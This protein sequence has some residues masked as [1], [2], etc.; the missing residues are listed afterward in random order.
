MRRREA[1]YGYLF[2][3]IWIIGY[4]IFSLYPVIFSLVLSFQEAHFEVGGYKGTFVGIDNYVSI[5][6][7][8]NV[9]PLLINYLGQII[10]SVPLIIVFA[11]IISLLINQPIR[12]KGIWRTIFFLPVVISTGPV[13]RTLINQEATSLP[14]I[15]N[16]P[17][18]EFIITNLGSNLATPI[19]TVLESLL[20]IL[21]YA[22]IPILIFLSALQRNER[23]IYEAAA[24]DGASPW[25]IFWKITLPT[26]MP[27]VTVNIVYVVVNL[28][29]TGDIAGVLSEAAIQS[30]GD[31]TNIRYYGYGYSSAITWIYFIM[32][33]SII[34]IFVGIVSFRGR[35]EARNERKYKKQYKRKIAQLKKQA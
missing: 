29:I 28:S 32:M 21:W 11:L 31:P 6:K 23:A 8:Q 2:I 18:I 27:F 26:I 35:R 5:F 10:I 33:V 9:L 20:L 22:G 34:G 15:T 16:N 25:D 30:S 19:T 4:L 3:S 1:L 7:N 12:G 14:S 13:I 24:I 17:I